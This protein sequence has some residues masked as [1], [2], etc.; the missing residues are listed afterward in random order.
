MRKKLFFVYCTL[1]LIAC[2]SH[3]LKIRPPANQHPGMRT[4]TLLLPEDADEH[5]V[6]AAKVFGQYANSD[7][8]Y[9]YLRKNVTDLE[10]GNETNVDSAIEKFR[11]CLDQRDSIKIVWTK[12]SNQNIG[13]VIGGWRDTYLAQNPFKELDVI[14]RASHWI[15]E[16]S[17]GCGFTHIDNDINAYPI[18]KRS[19]PYQVGSSF[20]EFLG[21]K[22]L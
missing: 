17:H 14:E 19:W 4:P 5:M 18:I 10:G 22:V 12:Y 1:Q 7:E 6:E 13:K 11:S 8:F 21:E 9:A 3:P 15:H 16:I 2:S 20:E